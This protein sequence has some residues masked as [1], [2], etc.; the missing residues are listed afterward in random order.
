MDLLGEYSSDEDKDDSAAKETTPGHVKLIDSTEA[1]P[2]DLFVREVPHTRGN[3]AGH[4]FIEIPSSSFRRRANTSVAAFC[5]RLEQAGWTGTVLSQTSNLHLSLSRPFFLQQ[6]SIESFVQSLRQRLS[7]ER[8]TELA[9]KGEKLLVNDSGTRS[10]WCWSLTSNPSVKRILSSVD[11]VLREYKQT[12]YYESPEFHVSLGSLPGNVQELLERHARSMEACQ[13]STDRHE[14]AS[15]AH[16]E[17]GDSS[18][19][20]GNIASNEGPLIISIDHIH[21]TFGTTKSFRIDLLS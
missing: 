5:S 6:S 11:G 1:E 3:W 9:V 12:T 8:R 10:F 4:V 20:D 14:L 21:I 18:S 7:F 17:E 13:D 19:D 16:D 15:G 2:S